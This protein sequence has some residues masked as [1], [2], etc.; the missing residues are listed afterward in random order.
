MSSK[1]AIIVG[2]QG[3]DGR[4]LTD[5]LRSRDYSILGVGRS[6]V[7]WWDR[8]SDV[9]IDKCQLVCAESISSAVAQFQPD[10]IYY[11]AAHHTSSQ[12][13]SEQSLHKSLTTGFHVNTLGLI[14]F[15]EAIRTQ[16]PD[17][18]LFYASSSLVY[19]NSVQGTPQTESTRI[20]PEEPYGFQKAASANICHEY[21]RHHQLFVST[22]ILYNHES[23]LRPPHFLS[24]KL[25]LA[26]IKA[27]YGDT[28]RTAI[29]SFD[30]IVDWGWAPDFVEAFTRIMSLNHP[31]DF[32]VSTGTPH[33]V[34]DFAQIAFTYFG[35]DYEDFITADDSIL[36]V[37]RHGRYGDPG[38]LKLLTN[39]KPTKTFEEM[40]HSII[41]TRML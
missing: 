30:V 3:Q 1:R 22:G 2:H 32:I 10:E 26:A 41:R 23:H 24:M 37:K 31:D 35:L 11:L 14:H 13:L 17:T 28:A 15:L 38:K 27:H 39:W 16:S 8:P 25:I 20:C 19:G 33:S 7:Q 18:R 29:G 36:R 4:L 34:R 9:D 21:R 12:G 5:L 6:S 40:I